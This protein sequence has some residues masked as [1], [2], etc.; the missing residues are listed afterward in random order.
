MRK[1]EVIA[2]CGGQWGDEG[3]GKIID[4]LAQEADVVIRAQGGDNAGHTVVNPF[5]KFGLHLI[6]AGIFNPFTENII[7]AGVA[8]NPKSLME[9]MENLSQ[10]GVPL[11]N[12]KI[13]PKAHLVFDY[14]EE[15]D[16]LQEQLKGNGKIGT[17]GRGIGPCYMDKAERVGLRAELLTGDPYIL[18]DEMSK[19]LKSKRDALVGRN[20]A[21]AVDSYLESEYGGGP[22]FIS[23][24]DIG[25][26]VV[27]SADL[28]PDSFHAEY[29]EELILN[30]HRLLAPII[31]DTD[32]IVHQR[33]NKNSRILIE[34]AH[35]TL[36]DL[37]HGTYPMVT[38]SSP[39]VAGL[40]LGSGIPPKYLTR[41]IGVFKAYQTRVGA[42]GMPTELKDAQGE[43]IRQKGHEFGT[44]TGR[45][46]RVG[47]FDTLA[48][49]YAMKMNGFSEIALTRLD[50]LSGVGDLK[51]CYE[52]EH[53]GE[54]LES[55]PT[56][57]RILGECSARY[58]EN[59]KKEGWDEDISGVRRFEDLPLNAQNY[60]GST[61]AKPKFVGVG[62]KRE[63]LIII[64]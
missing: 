38:S 39:T 6:P 57:S 24:E 31:T 2:V 27:V 1:P 13:S 16:K 45:P 30:A 18:L 25:R 34:G 37:D 46:R 62:E 5:G 60:I 22:G 48:W 20:L 61:I 8:L 29:Y 23:N 59:D 52:Y 35:G 4:Y 50:I 55:F 12:L 44:T 47:Y 28:I 33:L 15:L 14:H 58:L 42:G 7:G 41:S 53:K 32:E 3:K 54:I 64:K 17:T 36:L 40:L 51:I 10:H 19:A 21:A 56:D 63:D 11:D 43:L 26:M 49:E 9:E